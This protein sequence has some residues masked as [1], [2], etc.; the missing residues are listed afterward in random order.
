MKSKEIIEL[1]WQLYSEKVA[2]QLLHP[3]NEKMMQLQLAQILQ[4]LAPLYETQSNESIKVLLE[5]PVQ[6][7]NG[8]AII[9]IV[10]EHHLG[11][12]LEFTT[13]ELKCFRRYS[14]NSTTKQRGA[15]NLGMY[16]YWA[17]IENCEQYCHL[18][19]FHSAYQLTLTDDPY[20]VTTLH[21]GKQVIVYSTNIDRKNVSGILMQQIAN[22]KGYLELE[23]N[24][25]LP[26]QKKGD[27]YFI[28]QKINSTH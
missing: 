25:E 1:A 3:R 19:H 17:D 13:I 21:K 4:T 14:N 2:S 11:E 5:H 15:Q 23:G 16:D 8:T 24:Y 9:D 18:E 7:K 28:Q 27:F 22:R 10:I 26:W 6:I 20:Y 12:R